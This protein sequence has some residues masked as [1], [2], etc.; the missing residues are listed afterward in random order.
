MRKQMPKHAGKT[1]RRL[2]KYVVSRY[3]LRFALVILCILL[4][5][6]AN[7]IGAMFLQVLVD[8]YIAP[9]IGLTDPNFVGLFRA[10]CIMACIYAVGVCST[11]L[12][13]RIMLV[14]AQGVL[15]TIRDDMFNHMQDLPI[16]YFDTHAHGD[17]MSCYTN[18][19]D[20]LRQV[21]SQS[22]P[23]LISS[24]VTIVAVLTA[25]LL[26]NAWLTLVTVAFAVIILSAV[27]LIAGKSGKYF[28]RQQRSLGKVN[29]FI[30]EMINGQKVV[31]VFNREARTEQDFDALN[32]ELNESAYKA[33][34]YA[35]V[36]MPVVGNLGY[37]LYI[38]VAIVGGLLAIHG[39]GG[40]TLGKIVTF[41][42][43]SRSF[44]QP[45]GQIS[46]QLNAVIMAAAGAERIFALL[47][48]E[49]ERDE[50]YVTL[51]N[52]RLDASGT[53]VPCVEHTGMWAW[54]HPHGDGSV[55][56]TP[57]TGD[58]RF[59]DVD[60]AYEQDKPV[61]HEVS[62][63]AEPGQKIAFV[64]ATGAGKTTI[65]NLINRFYDIADGKIRYDEINI[66]KIRKSDLRHS[67][68]IVLQDTNLFTGTVKE[69]IKY[70]KPDASDE[71]VYAAA[72]LAHA[73]DFISRLPQGYDTVLQGNGANL[74]QGQRQ[75]ISIAR[76][77]IADAPVMILD[78]AT[79]SID[80]RTEALVQ[81]G[82]DCLMRGRTVFII[83]H[84]LSTVRNADVIIVLDHGRVVERGNHAELMDKRGYYYRLYTG[85][86]ELDYEYSCK[87][88]LFMSTVD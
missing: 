75:L 81:K 46:Q 5:A 11:Y 84:R 47:D 19:T 55:D 53:L 87:R 79:S 56:Y 49:P 69:N 72:Q 58:V 48:T 33:N 83:A 43:L 31:K 4:S 78:E 10:I 51:V 20:T 26:T 22:L 52:A 66:N 30:E 76:A 29:G 28:V 40:L 16:Q 45:I 86:F 64:G 3:K 82:M 9:M 80:T 50:G 74:S 44:S 61:L 24:I 25:M 8:D 12:Y 60:F 18:D 68:G 36:L 42:Q 73:D 54:R 41:L 71:E 13:N 34:Q 37:L 85:A 62:L 32:H 1:I 67:L 35:N 17:I 63:H 23:Q 27:R 7:V 57:L 38:V 77:A 39:I 88:L 21:I 2:L 65:T 70:G 15:K 59:F 6:A 14:V